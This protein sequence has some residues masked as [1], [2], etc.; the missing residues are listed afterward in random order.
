[1][2]QCPCVS[3][4]H[5]IKTGFFKT[6]GAATRYAEKWIGE[7]KNNSI[8]PRFWT[9]KPRGQ[10]WGIWIDGAA[11]RWLKFDDPY[12]KHQKRLGSWRIR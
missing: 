3:G 4:P 12:L 2:S 6:K 1:M 9:V 8:Y 5:G 11:F 7:E 10:A